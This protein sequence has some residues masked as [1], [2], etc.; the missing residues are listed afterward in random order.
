MAAESERLG[1]GADVGVRL[2]LTLY[3][4]GE[5][6][7]LHVFDAPSLALVERA[8]RR[9]GVVFD[10]VAAVISVGGGAGA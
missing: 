5:E 3:A 4:P 7:C 8:S 1:A 9:A 6:S 2:V 10:R